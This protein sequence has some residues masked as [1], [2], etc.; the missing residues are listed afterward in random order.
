MTVEETRLPEG[1]A[2]L[3]PFVARWAA[4]DIVERE[5]RRGAASEAERR[6][7]HAAAAPLVAAALDRLEGKP[8]ADLDTAE[9]RLFHMTL[10]YAHVALAVE[11]Q[12]AS[13]AAHAALRAHM[14]ITPVQDG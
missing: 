9:R 1:F 11:V 14:V 4:P 7:F 6:A 12:G 13:E 2:S 10:A 8:L 5:R 3:E